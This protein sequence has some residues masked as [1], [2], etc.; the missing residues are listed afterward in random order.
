VNPVPTRP[1]PKRWLRIPL[2]VLVAGLAVFATCE[3]VGYAERRQGEDTYARF[4]ADMVEGLPTGTTRKEAEAFLEA[5]QI[6]HVYWPRTHSLR[7]SL[8]DFTKPRLQLIAVSSYV[9]VDVHL[10]G[11]DRVREVSVERVWTGL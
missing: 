11:E 4:S 9:S 3:L 2:L 1:E 10:D 8:H 5:R 7:V 6:P